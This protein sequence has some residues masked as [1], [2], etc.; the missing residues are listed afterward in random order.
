MENPNGHWSL[1]IHYINQ[2]P[3]PQTIRNTLVIEQV[4]FITHFSKGNTNH[5]HL[6]NSMLQKT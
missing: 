1:I 3:R 2:C 4:E 5:E 6:G